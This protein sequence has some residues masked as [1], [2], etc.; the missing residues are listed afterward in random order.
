MDAEK[1]H[2]LIL[3]L[4]HRYPNLLSLPFK[5]QLT[6]KYALTVHG[7]LWPFPV[8]LAA[9]L[10]KNGECID[11]FSQIGFGAIEV[12]TVTPEE[13]PGNK[14]PRLFRYPEQKSLRNCMG[15][16][17]G[18]AE[19]LL[20]NIS[21]LHTRKLPL[22][23]N[24]GKNKW[25][26]EEEVIKDYQTLYEKFSPTASYLV[27]NISSPNTPGLRDLQNVENLRAIFSGLTEL[28]TKMTCPL[29]LKL[30]PDLSIEDIPEIIKI[31]AEFKLSGIIATNTTVI[32]DM[33]AGGISGE[34][35][36]KKAEII[37]TEILKEMTKFP[38]LS[39][40]GVGGISDYQ[41]LVTLWKSGGLVC[42]IYSSFI[43][44]GPKIL[45]KLKMAIDSDLIA[46]QLSNLEELVEMYR[47]EK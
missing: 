4:L 35:L 44:E 23:I 20:A 25:T 15:F 31:V 1:A 19:K 34:L 16:N 28:R 27:I 10:D 33:G 46:H 37:R 11:F 21:K 47:N 17:N 5:Q 7:V 45:S 2:D 8:G 26:T 24:L 30:S 14:R 18:G 36:K 3:N 9:G 29:Y 41:D 43:Y 38:E 40:I 39:F 13:Q 42:Q 22:G 32:E 12:G 6:E